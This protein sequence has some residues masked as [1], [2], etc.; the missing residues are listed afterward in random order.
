MKQKWFIVYKKYK[1]VGIVL[2]AHFLNYNALCY[3]EL[4]CDKNCFIGRTVKK[5]LIPKHGKIIKPD[6]LIPI[7]KNEPPL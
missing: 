3:L 5:Q 7:D 4:H 1:D 2:F 6:T